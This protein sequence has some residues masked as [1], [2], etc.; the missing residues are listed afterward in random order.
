M[1][2]KD[3]L[4]A[5][6]ELD[7]KVISDAAITPVK[8]KPG[9]WKIIL[10][11]VAAALVVSIVGYTLYPYVTGKK[12]KKSEET[13][14]EEFGAPYVM[15]SPKYPEIPE[16]PNLSDEWDEEKSEEYRQVVDEL[17]NQPEGYLDGY[18]EYL[19]DVL[20]VVLSDTGNKN[21]AISPLCLYLA[22]GMTAEITD[23]ETRQQILDVLH[24]PDIETLRDHAKSIWLANYMDDGL[25]KLVMANSLWTNSSWKYEQDVFD[26]LAS[27]YFAASYT[28][29][30]TQAEYSQAFRDWINEQTDGLLEGMVDDLELDPD[31]VIALVST[32]NYSAKWAEAFEKSETYSGIFQAPSG[33]VNCDYMC[34]DTAYE[35]Y[36]GDHFTCVALSTLGNGTVRFILP[37]EGMTPEELLQ[38]EEV[39]RF[40]NTKSYAWDKSEEYYGIHLEVP[41]FDISSELQMNDYL[42]ELGITDLFDP[43]GADFSPLVGKDKEGLAVS[44]V[45]QDTRVMIDEEGCKAASVV[46]V[47]MGR[48]IIKRELDFVLDRP[49]VFEIVSE[50]GTPLFVGIVND[51]SQS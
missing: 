30:P 26:T 46:M 25:S 32:V 24:Q 8:K 31:M 19:K 29:D 13:P 20:G 12:G 35:N 17:R 39:F 5:M 50:T 21:A 41:K 43:S 28:G 14:V 36:Y 4:D 49:F 37:E 23:G 7:E 42:K 27:E 44:S 48:G 38:D 45:V 9:K 10:G 51:P 11:G 34:T 1:N 33:E 3:M 15:A 2:G 18:D 47:L 40:L 22:L 6:S 16:N